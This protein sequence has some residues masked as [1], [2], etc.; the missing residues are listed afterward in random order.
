[1]I[2]FNVVTFWSSPAAVWVRTSSVNAALVTTSKLRSYLKS[3]PGSLMISSRRPSRSASGSVSR[4]AASSDSA[5]GVMV[6][7]ELVV[8]AARGLTR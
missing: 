1:M 2:T 7:I 3:S 5:V 6:M 8:S 4:S